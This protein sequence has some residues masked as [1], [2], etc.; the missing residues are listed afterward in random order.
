MSMEDD[1]YKYGLEKYPNKKSWV[2]YTPIPNDTLNAK[3]LNYYQINKYKESNQKSCIFCKRQA[4][5][6]GAGVVHGGIMFCINHIK[7]VDT[8]L[9]AKLKLQNEELNEKVEES[10]QEE[11]PAVTVIIAIKDGVSY[12]EYAPKGIKLEIELIN[13]DEE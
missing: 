12:V 1:F 13:Y 6:V 10:G 3:D 5:F 11:L 8:L 9:T 2:G 4:D 7:D